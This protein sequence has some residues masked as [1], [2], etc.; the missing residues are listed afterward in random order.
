MDS[1]EGLWRI[2]RRYKVIIGHTCMKT[3]NKCQG[4]VK[5]ANV[6]E[7]K[8]T[9][10]GQ[11]STH[12]KVNG[13]LDILGPLIPGT[14]QKRYLIVVTDYF[15]KWEEVKAVQH[16]RDKDVFTFIFENII[17]R[18]GIP[19]QLV[20][21]D[22]KKFEGEYIEMLLNAFKIQSGKST[23]LYPQS[24]GQ[25]EATNKTIADILKKKLEGYNKGWC[26]QVHN[27]V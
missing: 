18:F 19:A 11:C 20:S 22:G 26:K 5:S 1:R 15:T 27:A 23:L 7:R 17:C 24:N 3:R 8:Y 10:P 13:H 14:G 21:D 9:H 4:G 25:A 6:M 2:E 12:Q 16:I